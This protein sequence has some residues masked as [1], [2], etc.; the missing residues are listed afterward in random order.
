MGDYWQQN[1]D[2]RIE[3]HPILLPTFCCQLVLAA[4]TEHPQHFRK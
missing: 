4:F 1:E 2:N 3:S